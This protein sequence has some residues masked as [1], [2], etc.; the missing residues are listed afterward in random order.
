MN[1]LKKKSFVCPAIKQ[2]VSIDGPYK[3]NIHLRFLKEN[4]TYLFYEIL[5]ELFTIRVHHLVINWKF[6]HSLFSTL[7]NI[8]AES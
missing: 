1:L 3:A 7:R 2:T 6:Q 8:F 4:S 5:L